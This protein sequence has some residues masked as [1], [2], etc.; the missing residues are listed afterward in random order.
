MAIDLLNIAAGNG[1][2]IIRGAGGGDNVGQAVS[3]GDINGD[4]F[5]DLVIGAPGW[6]RAFPFTQQVGATYVVFGGAG[7]GAAVDLGT[8]ANSNGGFIIRGQDQL[9]STGWSV[10][11][12]GDFNGDGFNDM[13]IGAPEGDGPGNTRTGA[14]ESYLVFGFAGGFPNFPGGV[15][16]SDVEVGRGG[17]AIYGEDQLDWS[18]LSVANA[19][20]VNGDGFDDLII[21]AYQADGAG[22]AHLD[23]GDVYVVFGH[24]GGY[25]ADRVTGQPVPMNV[26][27]ATIAAGHGGF[28]IHGNN[29]AAGFSVASAGDVNGD[30][31]DDLLIGA[32]GGAGPANAR[33]NAGNTYV[34]FGHAGQ[35]AAEIDL[36]AV[37][38]GNGGFVI[39][40]QD[41]NDL[42]GW[43]VSSA[44]DINNDGFDDLIIGADE[45]DGPSN[46]RNLAGDTYVVFGAAAFAAEIDLAAVAAGAGGFVIHG[47]DPNDRSGR[48]VASAGDVNG[49]GYDDIIIG[50]REA[51]GPN[52]SR[53]FAGDSYVVF[54][55]AGGFAAEIDLAAVAAGNGGFVINGASVWAGSGYGVSSAGDVNGDGFDDLIVGA[56]LEGTGNAYVIFGSATIDGSANHVTHQGSSA[57]ET[58]TGD[59]SAN[60]MIGGRGNDVLIG[61]GGGDVLRGGEGNDVLS[62]ADPTFLRVVGGAGNDTLAFAGGITISDTDFRRVE[63]TESIRLGNGP[64]NLTLGPG[65]AHAID[66]LAANAF[67]ITI[68][69]SL[70]T[71]AAVTINGAGLARGFSIDL[72]NDSAASALTGGSGADVFVGGTGNDV[73]DGGAGNDFFRGGAGSDTL[74]GGLG[75][76]TISYA[77]SAAVTINLAANSL[78]GG[79][80]AGDVISGI[81]N[82]VGTSFA[83]VLTGDGNANTLDGG[84]GLDTLSGGDGNDTYVVDNT[85]DVVIE[86]AGQG[87]DAVRT[88]VS[89]S[90]GAG[91]SIE[92]FTTTDN[93]GTA[94]I[95]LTGNEFS[96]TI[97]GNDGNNN[98]A[99]GGSAAADRMEGRAGNDQ[100][101]V[102]NAGDILVE[103]GGQGFDVVRTSVSYRLTPGASIEAFTTTDHGGTAVINLTGNEFDQAI[104][105][106]DGD[107]TIDGAGGRDEMHGRAGNDQY[108]VD[109]AG[110]TVFELTGEGYDVVRASTNYTLIGGME[111]EAMT[112]TDHGGTAPINLTGNDRVQYILGNDGNNVLDGGGGADRLEGRLGND[113]YV[114]DNAGDVVVEL[115]GQ[116]T[117][118][119]RTSISYSLGAGAAIEEFSTTNNTG[120]AAMTLSGNEFSQLIL[121]ND[122]ANNIDGVGGA[123]TMQ[124]RLG[125]DQYFVD[126]AGDALVELAGQGYDVART[127]VSYTLTSGAAIEAL[128]TTNHGGTSAIDLT[129]NEFGQYILGNDGAN[130]ID[131]KA[132]AD[133]M[134]GR[135]GDD[136]Y[137]VDNSGDVLVELAGHGYDVVRASVSYT[138]TGGAEIEALTTTDHSGTAAINL[139][140]NEFGDLSVRQY[141]LGNDGNNIL[142][143]AGGADRMEGRLG[144]DTYFI[145]N[146]GDVVTELA[147]QGTDAVRTGISYSLGSG[148]AIEQFTTTNSSGTAAISLTGNE[149]SQTIVGNDGDNNI[150]GA[151]GGDTMQGRLGNDQYFVGNGGDVLVELAGQGYDVVRTSTSYTLTS[152]AEIEALTT[153]DHGGTAAIDLTGNE[154]DQYIQGNDGDNTINGGAGNDSLTGGG[155]GDQFLF[156]TALNAS[157]NVDT[158]LDY[159]VGVD[160]IRLE[161]GVFVGL[162]DGA[163]AA[164]AF[165]HGTAAADADDRIIFDDATG[166]LFFDADGAGGADAVQFAKVDNGLALSA[167]DFLVV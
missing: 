18:G 144:D 111:I 161:N 112:T 150:A 43:S 149:F 117:D 126:N 140:G 105:G 37:A 95:S 1:G 94:P 12:T 22:N 101:F 93:T 132:G 108:F 79:D 146:A 25:A 116:G 46:S 13:I 131:G 76:D 17:F 47:Q 151:G 91:V 160:Q 28:V 67:Q 42:S 153:T 60:V 75:S 61:G 14:G 70:V 3:A 115:A 78:S 122:G 10:S 85:G 35:F 141:L 8:V 136:Q 100:Y 127:S 130:T 90:L 165:A 57:G 102:D 87:T 39:R 154:F 104:T 145:D 83:D 80:A 2:F 152:G 30:G 55:K 163:L 27:L 92:E 113:T 26:D 71:N 63:S 41:P 23:S 120:T 97:V 54:G 64:T 98:I 84:A 129:G 86:P 107:N 7:A 109:N 164:G 15:N 19:G 16:L 158:I 125:D 5:D 142:D 110:D 32:I 148:A 106:N 34:V 53:D 45:A 138:L 96:Q 29:D 31:Y 89:Y 118:A 9:D 128:T 58:L 77:G 49:D 123:D 59:A 4:G 11:A 36:A 133:T 56:S 38:A 73:F 137:F 135:L 66:G 166:R 157:N 33:P 21:G 155:G 68:D 88:S 139:T 24:A 65:A 40:G 143:G 134:E 162:A 119:V 74:I 121:G 62:I 124:G 51:F 6:D 103:S 147:G 48:S 44:G 69:G 20:D 82:I 156:N 99:G 167:S 81:E 52:N 72:S 114:V 159:G 50:A